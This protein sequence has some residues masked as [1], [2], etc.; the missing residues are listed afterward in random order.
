VIGPGDKLPSV[1]KW[2]STD[3]LAVTIVFGD[4]TGEISWIFARDLFAD[5]VAGRCNDSGDGDVH[6]ARSVNHGLGGPSRDQLI[7]T[8]SVGHVVNLRTDLDQ[9]KIFLESTFTYSPYGEEVV[10]VDGA[11]LKLLDD[12]WTSGV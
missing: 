4:G 12:G 7:L 8:L 3:P 10:D 6:V 11:I 1:L 2:T 5:V 9:I